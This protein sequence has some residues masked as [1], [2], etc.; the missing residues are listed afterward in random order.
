MTAKE[1]LGQVR[2]L[3][4]EIEAKEAELE[5][6]RT[7]LESGRLSSLTGMPRGG[8]SDWTDT[9]AAMVDL[10]AQLAAEVERLT[11]LKMEIH[12]AIEQVED[13]RF[14]TLLQL[15]YC[16]GLTWAAVSEKMG[17]DRSNVWRLHERALEK[18]SPGRNEQKN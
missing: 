18:I 5:K 16:N 7:R 12:A 4:I 2:W 1:Y 8:G 6:I 13:P 11:C 14:R 9:A 15:R 3:E 10:E 17:Y